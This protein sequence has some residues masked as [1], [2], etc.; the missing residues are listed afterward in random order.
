MSQKYQPGTL[1]VGSTP[2]ILRPGFDI[3]G[4]SFYSTEG[5]YQIRLKVVEGW[6][7]WIKG[8]KDIPMSEEFECLAIEIKA[9][10]QISV[11]Y[12]LKGE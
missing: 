4:F 10:S 2:Q 12:F 7:G 5:D 6:G 8:F 11:E 9:S 1:T 3:Q